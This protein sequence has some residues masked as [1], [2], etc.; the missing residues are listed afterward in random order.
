MQ[1][2]LLVFSIV[3]YSA[4]AFGQ[5]GNGDTSIEGNEVSVQGAEDLVELSMGSLFTTSHL[6]K[7][8][9]IDPV[10]R[11]HIYTSQDKRSFFYEPALFPE[12]DAYEAAIDA[13][14]PIKL[15]NTDEISLE[16]PLYQRL[17]ERMLEKEQEELSKIDAFYTPPEE[18]FEKIEALADQTSESLRVFQGASEKVIRQLLEDFSTKTKS[19]VNPVDRISTFSALSVPV[20]G[21]LSTVNPS[22][23]ELNQSSENIEPIHPVRL[24]VE[25]DSPAYRREILSII[26]GAMKARGE[27]DNLISQVTD[28]NLYVIP[29]DLVRVILKSNDKFKTVYT[30]DP[31][32][33]EFLGVNYDRP[34]SFALDRVFEVEIV[35]DCKTHRLI[36][37][38]AKS[39]VSDII[40]GE[41]YRTGAVFKKT[42]LYFASSTG[43]TQ[44]LKYELL[45][46]ETTKLSAKW[47]MKPNGTKSYHNENQL[48]SAMPHMGP[49]CT[50][51]RLLVHVNRLLG[52]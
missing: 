30:S 1:R 42:S 14:C 12:W 45:T 34:K 32:T 39:G 29:Y 43:L 50:V 5:D 26:K 40:S 19:A 9:N 8:G 52:H 16:S 4:T 24:T 36:A 15:V 27:P 28:Y 2:L 6:R 18:Y 41:L 37:A 46:D 22:I 31:Q 17:E 20:L 3:F 11:V 21:G 49:F 10:K 51:R 33:I 25:M 44:R 23:D 48:G 7:L 35:E 13:V 47:G 38:Q